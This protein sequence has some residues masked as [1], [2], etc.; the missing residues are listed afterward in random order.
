MEFKAFFERCQN[1]STVSDFESY[2]AHCIFEKQSAGTGSQDEISLE[3][4]SFIRDQ[5]FE[6]RDEKA[7]RFLYEMA[8]VANWQDADWQGALR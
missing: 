8:A 4:Y 5:A 2:L 7:A 3:M 1:E 6:Q